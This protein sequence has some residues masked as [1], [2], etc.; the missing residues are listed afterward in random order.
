MNN[1]DITSRRHDLL[2][3]FEKEFVDELVPA[4]L[5]EK[6]EYGVEVL[7]VVLDDVAVEGYDATAE[8]FFLPSGEDDEIQYFVS[9]ITLAEDLPQENLSELCMAVSSI[10]TF[11]PAG[12][13]AIDPVARSLI[14]KHTYEMPIDADDAV[15]KDNMDLSMGVAMQMIISFAY[16]LVEVSDGKRT[17]ENALNYFI[18]MQ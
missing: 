4:K 3:L 9:L 6:D 10:N 17:A 2:A 11:I 5:S 13:F 16:L 1:G 7:A 8:Y 15:V 18:K 12:A 14:Y